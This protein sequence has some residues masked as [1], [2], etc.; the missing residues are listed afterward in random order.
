MYRQLSRQTRQLTV[1]S[2]EKD[3]HGIVYPNRDRRNGLEQ[4]ISVS[5]PENNTC[6]SVYTQTT[7]R[8]T[9][10]QDIMM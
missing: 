8:W 4:Q 10:L 5:R 2:V 6:L 3:R 1:I 9:V 7:Y